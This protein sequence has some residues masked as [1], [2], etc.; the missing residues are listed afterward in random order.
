M[1]IINFGSDTLSWMF[2]KVAGNSLEEAWRCKCD[3]MFYEWF[4]FSKH[5]A[6]FFI[7]PRSIFLNSTLMGK[8]SIGVCIVKA[9]FF[10]T[11]WITETQLKWCSRGDSLYNTVLDTEHSQAFFTV[12]HTPLSAAE[13]QQTFLGFAGRTSSASTSRGPIAIL[14]RL[15]LLLFPSKMIILQNKIQNCFCL[16]IWNKKWA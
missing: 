14:E 2:W 7:Y 12:S 16:I 15:L 11:Q 3:Q 4:L 8:I 13:S 1:E 10:V 6:L 9:F 5:T